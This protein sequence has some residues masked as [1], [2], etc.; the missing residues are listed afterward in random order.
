VTATGNF[1]FHVP[2]PFFSREKLYGSRDKVTLALSYKL[3]FSVKKPF[4]VNP[5]I[6]NATRQ[7][8]LSRRVADAQNA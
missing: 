3:C 6:C 4:R 1:L 5:V 7:L 2:I 8:K